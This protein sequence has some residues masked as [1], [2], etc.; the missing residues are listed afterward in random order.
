M[1]VFNCPNSHNSY[2]ASKEQHDPKCPE[3]GEPLTLVQET[4]DID[5]KDPELNQQVNEIAHNDE[6]SHH[7]KRVAVGK[8]LRKAVERLKGEGKPNA[9][10]A[11][12]TGMPENRIRQLAKSYV[13]HEHS[14]I[15]FPVNE[16]Y[17]GREGPYAQRASD[18]RSDE[19]VEL[20]QKR[21]QED[22][23]WAIENGHVGENEDMMRQMMAWVS[24][25]ETIIQCA[26]ANLDKGVTVDWVCR[27]LAQ[28]SQFIAR[29]VRGG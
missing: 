28:A 29:G 10:I 8:A 13:S 27:E 7:E 21:A 11:D 19:L 5:I 6:L 12:L 4:E 24:R 17:E 9:E 23:E 25:R 2:S 18:I 26:D 22:G 20:V 16:V 14:I 1:Y 15:W 3:C